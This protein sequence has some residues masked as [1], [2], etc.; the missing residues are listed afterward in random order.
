M[1]RRSRFHRVAVRVSSTAAMTVLGCVALCTSSAGAAP[2]LD[3]GTLGGQNSS[4][5]AINDL[6]QVTGN[7]DLAGGSGRRAFVWSRS[8]GM[9]DLGTLGGPS[10]T[11][12]GI[13]GSGEVTGYADTSGGSSHAFLWRAS[14]HLVDL[15][16]LGGTYSYGFAINDLG[17]VTGQ[18]YIAGDGEAHAFR[19][20]PVGM[21]DLGTLGGTSVPGTIL[22]VGD[23]I[24]SFGQVAGGSIART[25]QIHAFLSTASGIQDLG[26]LPGGTYSR[27]TVQGLNDLEE[28]T[29]TANTGVGSAEH[30]FLWTPSTGMRDLGTLG[31][32]SSYG[33]AINNLGEITGEA[34]LATGAFH[35][36]LW[37]PSRGMLDLG[38]LGGSSSSG[39]AINALG[40]VTGQAALPN[41]DSHA[42]LWTPTCGMQD[43]GTLGGSTS[44]GAAINIA[45]QVTGAAETSRGGPSHAFLW[46]SSPSGSPTC[47]TGAARA[48]PSSA[49]SNLQTAAASLQSAGSAFAISPPALKRDLFTLLRPHGDSADI[50]ALLSNGGQVSRWAV[51][52]A[53]RLTI[54][55]YWTATGA[56]AG[57]QGG[58]AVV[59]TLSRR[60]SRRSDVTLRIALTAEGKRLLR[61]RRQLRVT[62]KASF[63][64][65]GASATTVLKSFTLRR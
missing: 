13:N 9:D 33:V 62:G 14:G 29:G 44:S 17:Q 45:G 46:P 18:A 26:T 65:R 49:A 25:G 51:P 10:S 39:T 34:Q 4:G 5:V 28:V 54:S 3:L 32:A 22:S 42:F 53:G 43:L 40:D 31:G 61:S 52:G 41:G 24:N 30:A 20:T 47:T 63:A 19:W 59:A 60:F 56:S 6:G 36:F 50:R 58:R 23:A 16:T 8:A 48:T 27:V 2:M 38:T 15:G 11:S 37:T 64:P 57:R 7:A 21:E 1:S 12:T 35:A 55:W